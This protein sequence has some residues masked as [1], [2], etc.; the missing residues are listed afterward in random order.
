MLL[1]SRTAVP[2]SVFGDAVIL[3]FLVAQALDGVLT[4]IGV[5]HLGV[6]VE[7]NPLIATLITTI[8]AGPGLALAKA[9]ASF[10]GIL[11]HLVAVHRLVAALT[12]LYFG[13]AI[14]PW[15]RLLFF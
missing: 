2:R 1:I 4:Y 14:V 6:D 12:G 11:L 3:A 10:C 7:A 5:S 9:L 8:G 13:V 15:T